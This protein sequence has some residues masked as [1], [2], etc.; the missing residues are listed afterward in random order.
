MKTI[1]TEEIDGLKIVVGVGTLS[2]D[3]D[4]TRKAAVKE[5]F[6]LPEAVEM[7][8]KAKK[9]NEHQQLMIKAKGVGKGLQTIKQTEE[10]KKLL[11]DKAGNKDASNAAFNKITETTAEITKQET[12][13]KSQ[14]GAANVVNNEIKAII[15]AFDQKQMSVKRENPVYNQPKAGHYVDQ[16]VRFIFPPD[17]TD[18]EKAATYDAVTLPDGQSVGSL[19]ALF[20]GKSDNTQISLTG[21]VINDFRGCVYWHKDA[22]GTWVQESEIKDLDIIKINPD[23][24]EAKDLTPGQLEEIRFQKMTAEEKLAEFTQKKTALAQQAQAMETE[25]KFSG[26]PDFFSKAQEFYN[27]ELGKLKI[28]YNQ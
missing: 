10:A 18:E 19:S 22:A 20:L 6:E 3:P 5:I 9:K 15:P 25:L 21:N 8:G 17:V 27:T 2:I 7:A 24:I 26:D 28:K 12:E 1:I 23:A 16:G 14:M 4:A 13:Y 11:A